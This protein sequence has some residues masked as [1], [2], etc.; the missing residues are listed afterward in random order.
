MTTS[1]T[2][3]FRLTDSTSEVVLFPVVI[4]NYI[5]ILVVYLFI[6]YSFISECLSETPNT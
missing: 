6:I 5:F 3:F 4:S 2:L 1:A